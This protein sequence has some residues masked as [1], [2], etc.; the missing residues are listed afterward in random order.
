VRYRSMF[1]LCTALLLLSACAAQSGGAAWQPRTTPPPGSFV[2][3]DTIFEKTPTGFESWSPSA[4]GPLSHVASPLSSGT[5]PVAIPTADGESLVVSLW[6][7][8]E[9]PATPAGGPFEPPPDGERVARPQVAV[10]DL[11]T[12]ETSTLA[13]GAVSFAVSNKNQ[14]AYVKGENRDYFANAPFTG[15]IEVVGVTGDAVPR[16]LVTEPGNYRIV[17]WAN[18]FLLYYVLGDG[19]VL[20]LFKVADGEPPTLLAEGT[21]V[22][23]ISPDGSRVLVQR[24]GSGEGE[25]A[26]IDVATGE[27]TTYIDKLSDEAG[28]AVGTLLLHGDW[29]GDRI[30]AAASAFSG[31]IFLSTANGVL[32]VAE[33]TELGR[34]KFPWGLE[35]PRFNADLASVTALALI[36]PKDPLVPDAQY[37]TEVV[38]CD[39][40]T[41]TCTSFA[42]EPSASGQAFP[43]YN[44]SR[45]E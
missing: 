8:Y 35:A 2:L 6:S 41:N 24:L 32:E 5:S 17:A 21:G 40:A 37:V 9:T 4:L 33:T 44:P 22:V 23:A 30:V 12:G 18:E 34:D 10:I 39:I 14:V 42:P 36:P 3:E 45:A 16:T 38:T 20:N 1:G 7:L 29:Q 19:E 27:A 43:I 31:L 26:L 15:T 28:N 13:D 25:V 11:S